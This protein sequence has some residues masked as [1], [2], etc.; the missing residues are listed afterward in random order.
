MCRVWGRRAL[1]SC[2]RSQ[3]GGRTRGLSTGGVWHVERT[4]GSS[5]IRV[6][7]ASLQSD[8]LAIRLPAGHS[9]IVWG[10]LV[11]GGYRFRLGRARAP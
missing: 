8:G 3:E 10:S 11:S 9:E 5:A 6:N 4:G 7:V 1:P 2:G